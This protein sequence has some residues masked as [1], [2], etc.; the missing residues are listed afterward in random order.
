MLGNRFY[1]LTIIV[2]AAYL[3]IFRDA[4]REYL[5]TFMTSLKVQYIV[6]APCWYFK[7]EWANTMTQ[8]HLAVLIYLGDG[9][10]LLTKPNDKD[11]IY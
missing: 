10:V 5:D 11:R 3:A 2:N 9:L 6:D 7:P 4:N 8:A 1:P